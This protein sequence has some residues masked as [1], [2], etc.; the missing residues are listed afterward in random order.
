MCSDQNFDFDPRSRLWHRLRKIACLPN[1]AGT[2]H[3][4]TT[5][6]YSVSALVMVNTWV[7]I[8]EGLLEIVILANVIMCFCQGQTLFWPYPR[9]GWSD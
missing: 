7:N 8:G 5:Q 1:K 9:N 3:P 6:L 4:I 2:P